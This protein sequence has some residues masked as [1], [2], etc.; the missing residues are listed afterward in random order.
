[1]SAA[2]RI[3]T[4][5]DR[6]ARRA[7]SLLDEHCNPATWHGATPPATLASFAAAT[8]VVGRVERVE[9]EYRTHDRRAALRDAAYVDMLRAPERPPMARCP[10]ADVVGG[11]LVVHLALRLQ[12]CPA[13]VVA[14]ELEHADELAADNRCD[15]C[16]VE[17]ALLTPVG[18][19]LGPAF[20]I[21]HLGE[22][23]L[24]LVRYGEPDC[25]VVHEPRPPRNAP[26]PCGSGRKVKQCD[27]G[28]R[29]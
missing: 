13:C 8:A 14:A 11:A 19:T 12:G 15:C 6:I 22:C 9:V 3:A 26:C 29:P 5:H 21:A 1:V 4:V 28:G 16:G 25:L 10:H 27:C 17:R 23:C 18:T 2:D 24:E 20:V 7:L